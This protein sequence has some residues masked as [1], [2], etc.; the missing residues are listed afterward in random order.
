MH[1]TSSTPARGLDLQ[2]GFAA[3][4]G[5]YVE[6][7]RT[8][9]YNAPVVLSLATAE[10]LRRLGLII[11]KAISHMLAHY[12]RYLHL[13]PRDDHD[14][15][16]LRICSKYPC[17]VGTYRTDFVVDEADRLWIIE[18][19]TRQ[20]LN[21]Y[22]T[23]GFLREIAL[24][25]AERLGLKGVV[26]LYPRFF[27]YVE[28][29]LGR[30]KRVCA[31][32]GNEKLEEIKIYPAVFEQAG[33]P[34]HIIPLAELPQR[35]G[36]LDEAWVI[37]ELTLGEIRALPLEIIEALA[38][39]RL[40]NAIKSIL[41]SH[42]KRFYRVLNQAGFVENALTVEE[43]RLLAKYLTP[44][45]VYGDCPGLWEDARRNKEKYILK[46]QLKGKS[47]DV[48]AGC[49]TDEGTWE[50]LFQPA[51]LR[52]MVLQPM[53]RQRRFEG[54]VGKEPRRD[55]AAGTLLYFNDEWFGPG[56]FRTSTLPVSGLGDY[57]K[58]AALVASADDPVPG[59][60]YL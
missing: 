9:T 23:S 8:Y 27:S 36:L 48:Y 38:R 49:L 43:R 40:H 2:R 24:E 12:E 44:T 11:Y 59:V 56:L 50:R 54:F 21:G 13:M 47:V 33:L 39:R 46:H 29:H 31:I 25:Q 17:P 45:H 18:M 32:K 60:C 26:D 41:F 28:R 7:F 51:V 19:T 57:R 16:I 42:D 1:Q 20:P 5:G 14:L 30:A 6:Y 53:V 52:E 3:V 35:L 37:E 10:E 58:I 22:F 34:C 4:K 55:Y 15:E